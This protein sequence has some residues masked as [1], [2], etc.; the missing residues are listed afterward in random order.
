MKQWIDSKQYILKIN[1]MEDKQNSRASQMR[2][3]C[4]VA[5]WVKWPKTAWKLQNQHF[6]DKTVGGH[7]GT[8]QIFWLVGR[9][10]PIPPTRE[11]FE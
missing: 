4:E 5:V 10:P 6:G 1:G 9:D 8:S 11:N 2:S 3:T 7:G